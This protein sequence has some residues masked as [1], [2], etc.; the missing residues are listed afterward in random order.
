MNQ[1]KNEDILF[2]LNDNRNCRSKN[3]QDFFRTSTGKHMAN[4]LEVIRWHRDGRLWFVTLGWL[5]SSK[6][7]GFAG[8]KVTTVACYGAKAKDGCGYPSEQKGGD[9]DIVTSWFWGKYRERGMVSIPEVW[10]RFRNLPA[11]EKHA[12]YSQ[13]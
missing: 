11:P 12:C 9:Y 5:V 6:E 13:I 2:L 8:V 4:Q 1:I 10:T 7:N 3:M